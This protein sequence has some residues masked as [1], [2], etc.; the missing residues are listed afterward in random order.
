MIPDVEIRKVRDC[1]MCIFEQIDGWEEKYCCNGKCS[2]IFKNRKR[3]FGRRS[4]YN[5]DY[6]Q[7]THD[8]PCAYNVTIDETVSMI[9]GNI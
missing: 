8:Y 2:E 6:S 4:I 5:D 1:R 7:I 9:E 3:E